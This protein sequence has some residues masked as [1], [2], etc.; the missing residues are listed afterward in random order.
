M[1]KWQRRG[2]I[3]ARLI[4][5]TVVVASAAAVFVVF[6]A[7]LEVAFGVVVV[8]HVV[9][10]VF[11]E[12]VVFDLLDFVVFRVFLLGRFIVCLV[13]DFVGVV[14]VCKLVACG[15]CVDFECL[16]ARVRVVALAFGVNY[17]PKLFREVL[18]L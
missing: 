7:V 6:F 18:L 17:V 9:V 5:V 4:P 11:V 2:K 1:M 12:F 14:E 8:S 10:F 13:L 15:F 3:A 16:F